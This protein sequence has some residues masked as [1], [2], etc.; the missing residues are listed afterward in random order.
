MVNYNTTHS[1]V[2]YKYLL[3][4]FY[5]KTNKKLYDLKIWQYNIRHTYIIAIKDII[6]LE[7]VRE[8]MSCEKIFWTKM[9]W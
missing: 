8:K 4:V 9:H 1:K 5:N 7:K 6:V 3:K 2:V